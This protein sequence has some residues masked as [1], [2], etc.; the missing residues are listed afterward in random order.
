MEVPKRFNAPQR[1]LEI[2]EELK[3]APRNEPTWKV[4]LKVYGVGT[5]KDDALMFAYEL[6]RLAK[7]IEEIIKRS[8]KIP[9]EFLGNLRL[10]FEQCYEVNLERSWGDCVGRL[11]PE[12][13]VA[14][15]AY[16]N[17]FTAVCSE[18]KITKEQYEELVSGVEELSSIV[19][20][21]AHEELRE[22][23]LSIVES[24]RKTIFLY[25]VNGARPFTDT[26][27]LFLGRLFIQ[28]NREKFNEGENKKIVTK[29]SEFMGKM[30]QLSIGTKA[31]LALPPAFIEAK[32]ALGLE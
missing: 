32:K 8:E 17:F 6:A 29:M 14:L 7:N 2:I 22:I 4:Y 19:E 23:L 16:A 11:K 9:D 31:V 27:D 28:Y 26:Y 13:I 1:L 30:L 24:A 3:A 25:K 18:K 21:C 5:D 12:A 10:I 15:T 20:D